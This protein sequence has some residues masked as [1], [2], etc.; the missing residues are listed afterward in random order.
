MHRFRGLRAGLT[1]LRHF[2]AGRPARE[3][4]EYTELNESYVKAGKFAPEEFAKHQA[5]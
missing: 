3:V 5:K 2:Y 4:K 1:G